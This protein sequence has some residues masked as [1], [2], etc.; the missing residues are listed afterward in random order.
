MREASKVETA[1]YI[2]YIYA[3][4][5]DICVDLFVLKQY[6]RM[7]TAVGV[8][9]QG[10]PIVSPQARICLKHSFSYQ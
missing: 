4:S 10:P 3:R 7:G 6:S 8:D 2:T 9:H 1:I 5:R